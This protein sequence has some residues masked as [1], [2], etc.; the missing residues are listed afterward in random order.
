MLALTA[1]TGG[2]DD[3]ARDLA[4]IASELD[5]LRSGLA[6]SEAVSQRVLSQAPVDPAP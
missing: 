6:E 1:T 5:G 4:D 2:S 3:A